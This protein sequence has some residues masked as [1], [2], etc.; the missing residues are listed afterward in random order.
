MAFTDLLLP[1]DLISSLRKQQIE[2]LTPIQIAALPVLM[3]LAPAAGWTAAS[4]P[5]GAEPHIAH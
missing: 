5:S 4:E 2:D 3:P 1:A